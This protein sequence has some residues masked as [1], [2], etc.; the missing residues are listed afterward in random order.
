MRVAKFWIQLS[1]LL[2]LVTSGARAYDLITGW[3]W[4]AG[5]LPV[6]VGLGAHSCYSAVTAANE[7]A[8]ANVLAWNPYLGELQFA[9]TSGNGGALD[10]SANEIYWGSGV[11]G[12]TFPEGVLV[13]TINSPATASLAQESDIIVNTAE[14]WGSSAMPQT[15]MRYDLGRVIL[16]E[17]GH[18]LGLD[19]PDEAYQNVAAIMNSTYG[20]ARALT[21]DDMEG[22]FA[23][24]GAGLRTPAP[25][26]RTHPASQAVDETLDFSLNATARFMKTCRWL[27]EGRPIEGA[28]GGSYYGRGMSPALAG[29][30]QMEASNGVLTALSNPAEITM[31]PGAPPVLTD[32]TSPQTVKEGG[33]SASE[34]AEQ[35]R[36][37]V[38]L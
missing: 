3:R 2:L 5:T 17:A 21:E 4:P 35:E 22:L 18:I 19:H 28:T 14:Q 32:F 9:V 33:F 8:R 24:Y 10:N 1:L 23:Y 38:H 12:T 27:K 13:V 11:L 7:V 34:C 36:D 26:F 20:S 25:V 31:I 37:A 15:T 30:Y 16:H 6:R 29:T